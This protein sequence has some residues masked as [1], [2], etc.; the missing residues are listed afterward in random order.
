MTI[1]S[2]CIGYGEVTH[3]RET[4]AICKAQVL[5]L[6]IVVFGKFLNGAIEYLVA[7]PDDLQTLAAASYLFG[8]IKGWF[9]P[10]SCSQK[11]QCLV[12]NII[13][14]YKHAVHIICEYSF[15]KSSSL[16]MIDIILDLACV[17]SAGINKD[18]W[19]RL[20]P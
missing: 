4:G 12:E 5:I 9:Q 7:Y 19:E 14:R 11:C 13:A 20:A 16:L 17:P 3:D 18:Q 2:E 6:R 8:E 1:K 10:S 15:R